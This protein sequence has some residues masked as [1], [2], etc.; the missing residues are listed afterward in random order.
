MLFKRNRIIGAKSEKSAKPLSTK[1]SMLDPTT[2]D[3]ACNKPLNISGNLAIQNSPSFWS[4]KPHQHRRPLRSRALAGID[5]GGCRTASINTCRTGDL[6]KAR[7]AAAR[8]FDRLFLDTPSDLEGCG[9]SRAKVRTLTELLQAKREGTLDLPALSRVPHEERLNRLT[10]YW[11]IGPWS[12]EMWSL[13][14]CRTLTSGLLA[15][16]HSKRARRDLP[17]TRIP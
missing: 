17:R 1:S 8:D 2:E 11:G 5:T 16:W 6:D 10:P 9:L 14:H 3:R 13:F 15:I 12:V 7:K 4:K